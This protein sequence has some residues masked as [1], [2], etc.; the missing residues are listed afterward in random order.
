MIV[1]LLNQKQYSDFYKLCQT[2][3]ENPSS[4]QLSPTIIENL[5]QLISSFSYFLFELKNPL[6]KHFVFVLK[7]R[8]TIE[9]VQLI[10]MAYKSISFDDL[11]KFFGLNRTS[12]EQICL[13]RHWQMDPDGIHLLPHRYGSPSFLFSIVSR[14]SFLLSS[15]FRCSSNNVEFELGQIGRTRLFLRTIKHLSFVT[16]IDFI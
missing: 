11:Q 5:R 14:F 13:E 8:V 4:H 1:S 15:S 16:S 12:V 2:A 9:N 10:E 7:D 6:I 3:L